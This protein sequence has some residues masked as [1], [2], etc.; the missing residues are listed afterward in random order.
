MRR[1]LF[2]CTMCL[3]CSRVGAQNESDA[4]SKAIA[5][6]STI[7]AT[8]AVAFQ[9]QVDSKSEHSNF[10]G[11]VNGQQQGKKKRLSHDSKA[12]YN[13]NSPKGFHDRL[14]AA[15]GSSMPAIYAFDGQFLFEYYPLRLSMLKKPAIEFSAPRTFGSIFPDNWVSVSG[16]SPLNV[17][18][19][20]SEAH[21]AIAV[22]P[23]D[24][25]GIWV[26]QK[27]YSKDF[28]FGQIQMSVD[29][30]KGW[31]PIRIETSGGLGD[32]STEFD[33]E[34][35]SKSGRWFP[36]TAKIRDYRRF[37]LQW[38]IKAIDFEAAAISDPFT[39][40]DDNLPFGTRVTTVTKDARGDEKKKYHFIGG[41]DGEKEYK[42]R[43]RA[44]NQLRMDAK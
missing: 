24:P 6:A 39:L 10:E 18:L 23:A 21:G 4:R 31:H 26:F 16:L 11:I 38:E 7:L 44:L 28:A 32:S 17:N 33:W 20:L 5:A 1:I 15:S 34:Q 37:D 13:P 27:T 36:R 43:H 25:E 30:K 42:L 9:M 35:D 41:A 29:P 14:L 22:T 8:E 3:L 19:F 12:M 40:A 2:V